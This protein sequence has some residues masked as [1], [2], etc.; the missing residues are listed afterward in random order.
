MDFI[1]SL[2]P[3][4]MWNTK[5]KTDEKKKKKPWK[6]RFSHACVGTNNTNRRGAEHRNVSSEIAARVSPRVK[7]YL[8]HTLSAERDKISV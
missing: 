4:C 2:N 1:I 7:C 8:Q 3:I 5:Y 6:D